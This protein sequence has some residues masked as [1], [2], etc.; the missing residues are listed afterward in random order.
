MQIN[1]HK[2]PNKMELGSVVVTS[3]DCYLIVMLKEEKYSAMSLVSFKVKDY[4]F[5]TPHDV[6][7]HLKEIYTVIKV[8]HTDKLKLEEIENE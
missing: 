2:Q 5:K 7:E 3:I 6:I 1:I 4:E 8:I